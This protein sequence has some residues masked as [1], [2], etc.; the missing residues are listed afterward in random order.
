[1]CDAVIPYLLCVVV[2]VHERSREK[3]EEEE[4]KRERG[5]GWGWGWGEAC[6]PCQ[7]KFVSV[8]L[9]RPTCA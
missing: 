5:R 9:I 7:L 8:A 1:M 6:T 2:G 4:R 3:E